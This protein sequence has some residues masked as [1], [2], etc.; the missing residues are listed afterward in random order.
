MTE[1]VR[2]CAFWPLPSEIE[3]LL[4]EGADKNVHDEH[5][6]TPSHGLAKWAF[7]TNTYQCFLA[8]GSGVLVNTL[9]REGQTP[10]H[11]AA[12]NDKAIGTA[13]FLVELGARI[14]LTDNERKT[15]NDYATPE[16]QGYFAKT[17]REWATDDFF[18][19]AQDYHPTNERLDQMEFLVDQGVDVNYQNDEGTCAV[20]FLVRWQLEN[21]PGLDL[22]LFLK[23]LRKKGADFTLEDNKGDT[24][25]LIT[26]KNKNFRMFEFLTRELELNHLTKNKNGVTP[27]S[28]AEDMRRTDFVKFMTA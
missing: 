21:Q 27:L 7:N 10:L 13:L 3:G 18:K 12:M 20:M 28:L 19:L 5:G 8:L 24:P 9:N 25:L 6:N 1:L 4:K 15:P 16:L 26:V 11:V 2:R 17:F 14:D 23:L 22:V